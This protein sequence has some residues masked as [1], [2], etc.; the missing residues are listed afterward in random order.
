MYPK[1]FNQ[2]FTPLNPHLFRR[3]D[4]WDNYP[5]KRTQYDK[6]PIFALHIRAPETE[7]SG[8]TTGAKRGFIS[9]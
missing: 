5:T 1:E 6:S 3:F 2:Q 4:L 9:H 7:I 8:E